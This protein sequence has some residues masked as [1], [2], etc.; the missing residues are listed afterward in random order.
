MNDKI[1]INA[2]LTVDKLI[3]N[4]KVSWYNKTFLILIALEGPK[5]VLTSMKGS[6]NIISMVSSL[7]LNITL[8]LALET[9]YISNN[10]GQTLFG[11]FVITSSLMSFMAVITSMFMYVQCE[12]C[13][14]T[15]YKMQFLSRYKTHDNMIVI[16]SNVWS[17]FG[18]VFCIPALII[19][20]TDIHG[21]WMGA[22]FGFF[23][24]IFVK[25]IM[26][27]LVKSVIF[28]RIELQEERFKNT[29]EL[30]EKRFKN[31][32]KSSASL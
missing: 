22:Y 15:E 27:D 29:I 18:I 9:D 28:K 6:L 30:E 2:Y 32:L 4:K 1:D 12:L 7:F 3:K 21:I 24:L 16:T 19:K 20:A 17:L 8:P 25:Y 5:K 26:Y 14:V 23:T 31:I 11:F 13:D 10:I